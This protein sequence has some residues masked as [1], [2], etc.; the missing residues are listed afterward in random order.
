MFYLTKLEVFN[1]QYN[2]EVKYRDEDWGRKRKLREYQVLM[3]NGKAWWRKMC[4]FLNI[5]ISLF[6]MS[7]RVQNYTSYFYF[8]A[9][10]LIIAPL[11]IITSF[12]L[13]IN[14]LELVEQILSY[15]LHFLAFLLLV[16][17][18]QLSMYQPNRYE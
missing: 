14:P 16:V 11:L 6:G 13:I 12:V 2:L 5:C 9:K 10:M 4:K 3:L 1:P 8:V 18:Y 7:R 17:I 15:C